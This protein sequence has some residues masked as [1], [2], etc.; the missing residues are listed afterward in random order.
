MTD[1]TVTY[2]WVAGQGFTVA[3]APKDEFYSVTVFDRDG[4]QKVACMGDEQRNKFTSFQA[5][6]DFANKYLKDREDQ[7]SYRP[8]TV[9]IGKVYNTKKSAR[10]EHVESEVVDL[11]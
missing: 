8:W 10:F 7:Q 4:D 6:L 5:A 9:S 2:T 11:G 1:Q 3:T